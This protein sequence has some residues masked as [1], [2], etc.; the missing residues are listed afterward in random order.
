MY[1]TTTRAIHST[2]DRKHHSFDRAKVAALAGGGKILCEHFRFPDGWVIDEEGDKATRCDGV[3]LHARE[4]Q[5]AA[6]VNRYD[7]C[8]V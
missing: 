1:K 5:A 4:V 2:A 3:E 6:R 7:I 8:R